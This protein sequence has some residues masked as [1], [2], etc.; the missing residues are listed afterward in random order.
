MS[1]RY[2]N[3]IDS[4]GRPHQKGAVQASRQMQDWTRGMEI[5]C[6]RQRSVIDEK[7]TVLPAFSAQ[8]IRRDVLAAALAL[9]LILFA[10]ILCADLEALYAGGE[11]IGKLSAGIASLEDT[12]ALLRDRLSVAMSHPVL[13]RQAEAPE[14]GAD[15]FIIQSTVPES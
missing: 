3:S 5:S 12:N 1:V 14:E 10:G 2:M 11:R 4:G 15:L 6:S 9:L 7:R 13:V 8:G